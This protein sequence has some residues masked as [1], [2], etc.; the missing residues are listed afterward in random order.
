[1][2]AYHFPPENAIGG[3]RPYHFYKYLSRM[4]YRC[5]VITAAQQS[6]PSNPDFEYVCD[7]FP[8]VRGIGWQLER[9]AR[10][11]LLPGAAGFRWSRLAYKAAW[12]FL[13][14]HQG[15]EVTIFSTSPPLGTHL[16]ACRLARNR[17]F[18][19]IADFRD[20]LADD[21]GRIGL[22]KFQKSIY[23]WLERSIL[24][25]STITI[26]NTDALADKLKKNYPSRRDHV[27]IIWNGF[28]PEDRVQP[29]PPPVND[30]LIISHI[31]ELYGGRNISPLLESVSR[32]IDTG[33]LAPTTI[34][35]RLVGPVERD[36]IPPKE[37]LSRAIQ[38]GWLE[39]LP[40]LV[41]KDEARRMAQDSN[42][43]LVVQP[44]TT[45]QVPGKVFEYLRLGRPIL[46]FI[47]PNTP[48]E[49]ILRQ[50]GVP[51]RCAYA[52]SSI[53]EM[54]NAVQDF[55]QPVEAVERANLWFEEN[56]NAEKQTRSLETLIQSL[57]HPLEL[58]RAVR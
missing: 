52:G 22:A 17:Q 14:S 16:A 15:S 25:S 54:D 46:A 39:V 34:R 56:F 33:R 8:D 24:E 20:P 7:P 19:W 42:G 29:L 31:G 28:D 27:H 44:H 10:K 18:K 26:A 9:A 2:F 36:C 50:S 49:R 51:Y 11:F 41:S 4:G 21:P 5:H 48:T 37:F 6:T 30:R 13:C 45:I 47:L 12:A 38:Q 58:S 57:H 43:L 3:A 53:Q 35:I 40:E 23:R 55:F 1:M 32:L